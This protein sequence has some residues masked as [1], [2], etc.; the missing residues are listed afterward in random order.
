ME[1]NV[2]QPK[3]SNQRMWNKNERNGIIVRSGLVNPDGI[4]ELVENPFSRQGIT[5]EGPHCE[6]ISTHLKY[7]DTP[8]GLKWLNGGW[9]MRKIAGRCLINLMNKK[10]R[11]G[12]DARRG[13]N[14]EPTGGHNH[15]G[16]RE[17]CKQK[18][19][20]SGHSMKQRITGR[21]TRGR[22]FSTVLRI[23]SQNLETMQ[24]NYVLMTRHLKVQTKRFYT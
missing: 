18:K 22:K 16:W 21:N 1:A 7:C 15:G 8:G 9:C 14:S 6:K 13:R 17:G 23:L 5:L 4:L 11:P 12:V 24:H 2:I 19:Q 20:K 10:T 3:G